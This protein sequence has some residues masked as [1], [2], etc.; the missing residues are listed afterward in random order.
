MFGFH[1]IGVIVLL[2]LC[3]VFDFL[4]QIRVVN[5]FR[6]GLDARYDSRS[7]SSIHSFHSLQTKGNRKPVSHP[8][9][10]DVDGAQSDSRL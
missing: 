7:M 3:C 8:S 5:A 1:H 10:P 6:M 4:F 2:V 9:S